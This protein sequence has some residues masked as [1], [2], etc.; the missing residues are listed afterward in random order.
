MKVLFSIFLFKKRDGG[1]FYSLRSI[2][3]ELLKKCLDVHIL[4]ISFKQ[5]NIFY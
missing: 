4:I 5:T 1:H 2:S 3:N